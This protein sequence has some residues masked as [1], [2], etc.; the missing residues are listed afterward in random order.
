[1]RTY[2][3]LRLSRSISLF[4]SQPGCLMCSRATVS[5]GQAVTKM[6]T[7]GCRSDGKIAVFICPHMAA[8]RPG[9]LTRRSSGL[10]SFA[11]HLQAV[12]L[13]GNPREFEAPPPP[14]ILGDEWPRPSERRRGFFLLPDWVRA[15]GGSLLH[16]IV[17]SW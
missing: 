8:R 2:I 15:R 3:G 10:T 11:A 7:V 13:T 9:E 6:R 5:L 12:R 16:T 17:P 4:V 1:M 14:R